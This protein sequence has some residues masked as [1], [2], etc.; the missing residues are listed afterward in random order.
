MIEILNLSNNLLTEISDFTALPRLRVLYLADNQL[1]L[2]EE[3]G[4]F[5]T[6]ANTADVG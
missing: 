2:G 1:Y 4:M 3:A 5:D 6:T